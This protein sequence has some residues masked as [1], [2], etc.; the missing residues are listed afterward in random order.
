MSPAYRFTRPLGAL[1]LVL[2]ALILPPLN[3]AHAHPHEFVTMR[4]EA[5]FNKAGKLSGF[6]YYWRFDEFFSAYAIEGQDKNKNGKAEQAE[7]DAL[8]KEI[9]GNIQSIDYFT[10]FDKNNLTP[11]LGTA[12]PIKATLEKRELAIT[13]DVPLKK[14]VSLKDKSVSYA[15]Y[16]SEFYIAMHHD[17]DDVPVSLKNAPKG[18][19]WKL[20]EATPDEATQAFASSLDKTDS[21]G[22]GVNLGVMFAEWVSISCK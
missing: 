14:A 19:S 18:C 8:L 16:D 7:L 22:A 13:F 11:D 1:L 5:Q 2:A 17:P 3:T 20:D 6:R 10:A 15:I 4:I 12:K 21:P 9:L